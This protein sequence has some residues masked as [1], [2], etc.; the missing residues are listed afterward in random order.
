MARFVADA[1]VCR[2]CGAPTR[3]RFAVCYCCGVL[4]RQLRMPLVPTVAM[5]NY[6]IGD[7]MHRRLRRY[8]DAP[9]AEVRRIHT[10]QLAAVAESWMDAYGNRLRRQLASA[11]DVVATVPSTHRP[12]GAPVDA[13][14]SRV[15]QLACIH[16]PLLARGPAST[17][18]LV[19]ARHGF[20]VIPEIDPEWL[21]SQRVLVVDDST[22][23]GARAQSAAAALR[24]SGARV[25]GVVAIGRA[26]ADPR[27][28]AF[29]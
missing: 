4:V 11:W 9:V 6:G 18:H 26:V 17:D 10:A 15:A 27:E 13:V 14:V 25:V 21:R 5:T 24:L 8:K 1:V 22:I 3:K 29:D 16:Q 28:G 19:A 20:E 2:V 12:V 7:E 23:T